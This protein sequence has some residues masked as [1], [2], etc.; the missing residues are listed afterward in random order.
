VL[1]GKLREVLDEETDERIVDHLERL[2]DLTMCGFCSGGNMATVQACSL[3][4]TFQEG[5]VKDQLVCE[6]DP[7]K[8]K[9]AEFIA[10]KCGA[11]DD[12]CG[13]K[14]ITKFE[15]V[16]A[17]SDSGKPVIVAVRSHC[18]VHNRTC[19]VPIDPSALVGT[20]GYSCTNLSKLF[21]AKDGVSRKDLVDNLFTQRLGA[22]GETGGALLDLGNALRFKFV[23]WENSPEKLADA[24]RAQYAHF[25]AEGYT[26]GFANH[27]EIFAFSDHGVDNSRIRS[28]GVQVEYRDSK[29]GHAEAKELAL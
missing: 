18:Q 13:F 1:C 9:L 6:I 28:V 3:C 12:H 19:E 2:G 8:F 27:G 29:L 4:S 11:D 10:E 14:D 21:V 16:G 5:A 20:C 23:M 24:N 22:S 26:N 15:F 7:S 25:E 17:K